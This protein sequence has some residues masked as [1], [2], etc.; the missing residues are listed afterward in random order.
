MDLHN[1]HACRPFLEA[2]NLSQLSA[3]YEEG[4]NIMWMM[5]RAQ[6]RPCFNL[7]LVHDILG[8]AQAAR[9]SGLPIDFWVTGSLIPSIYNVGGDLDFFAETIRAG[10]RQALMS[11]A[12]ACVDS[13]FR[14]SGAPLPTDFAS[15]NRTAP[16]QP[17][18]LMFSA[19]KTPFIRTL[20]R[21]ETKC[22]KR[23]LMMNEIGVKE[24]DL[25][26]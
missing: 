2:G 7:E 21:I 17:E 5:L 26:H 4:R 11:Y 15:V 22:W 25:G 13:T 10:R 20:P 12:R 19:N 16:L 9:D 18:H 23:N 8:L 1:H 3:Y 6:P 24:Y 14:L